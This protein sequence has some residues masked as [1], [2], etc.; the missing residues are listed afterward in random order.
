MSPRRNCSYDREKQIE[1]L[2]YPHIGIRVLLGHQKRQYGW[3]H[4]ENQPQSRTSLLEQSKRTLGLMSL[5]D[6]LI[7]LA[8]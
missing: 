1:V 5:R 2:I 7:E 6:F 4:A 3:I 8:V